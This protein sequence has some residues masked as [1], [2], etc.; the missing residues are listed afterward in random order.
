MASSPYH[1]LFLHGVKYLAQRY[2][3]DDVESEDNDRTLVCVFSS[4]CG[5]YGEYEEDGDPRCE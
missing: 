1:R 4:K 2:D 3:G 5:W